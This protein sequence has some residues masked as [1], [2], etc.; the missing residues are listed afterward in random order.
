MVN[1]TRPLSKYFVFGHRL[2]R[3]SLITLFC[4]DHGIY[5][6]SV[7][8]HVESLL[9][10]ASDRVTRHQQSKSYRIHDITEPL[11]F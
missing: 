1:L 3:R 9:L 10:F 5:S 6:G 4:S 2:S 8:V 7:V 11:S